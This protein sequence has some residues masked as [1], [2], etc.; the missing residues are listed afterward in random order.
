MQPL[1]SDRP[2]N[3]D[4]ARRA[5]PAGQ[6]GRPGAYR[7]GMT[8]QLMPPPGPAD[9]DVLFAARLRREAGPVFADRR[10]HV[11]FD[12]GF[13]GRWTLEMDHGRLAVY[14]GARP[15]P[16]ARVWTD[17]TTLAAVVDGHAS[18]AHAFVEHRLVMRGDIALA[19]QLDGA[20]DVPDRPVDHPSAGVATPLGVRTAYLQ[21]GPPDAPP[22]VLLHGIGAT[23][24]SMLPLLVDLGRDFRVVAPDLP[25]FG[26]SAAPPW[27]YRFAQYADWFDAF[28]DELGIPRAHVVSNSLGGRITLEAALLHPDR[29][30]RLVLLCPSPAFRRLRQLAPAVRLV[31]PAVARL[32]FPVSHGA[33]VQAL[34]SMFADPSRLPAPWYDAAADQFR[35]VMRRPN[36]RQAFLACLRQIYLDEAFGER[37]FW[38]RLP[39][40]TVPALFLWGEQDWL[41]PAGFARHVVQALPHA[42]SLVLEDCGHVPQ[43]EH[44]ATTAR[45]TREFLSA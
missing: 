4:R 23:N 39:S 31:P 30:D 8:A 17:S 15:R 28:L 45:L 10:A 38:D 36:A 29:V 2:G 27:R 25:G 40:V 3:D 20:F 6:I 19:L 5:A 14:H 34:R 13:A 32:P 41:V 26:A 9:L 35:L 12:A 42:D 43:F 37:G 44:P 11:V 21:A 16:D 18:G 33:T 22:V 24:A 1:T 7:S